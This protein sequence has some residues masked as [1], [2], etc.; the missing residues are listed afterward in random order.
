MNAP[1]RPA[2]ALGA[3]RIIIISANSPC[4]ARA[5]ARRHLVA[6]RHRRRRRPSPSRRPRR[7]SCRGP[8]PTPGP[9]PFL[10][11]LR[12]L[13]GGTNMALRRRDDT[14]YRTIEYMTVSPSP[15]ELGRLA[16]RVLADKTRGFRA[17]REQDNY[18]LGKLLRGAGDGPGRRELLSDS[19]ST[20][21]TSHT[22]SSA[23]TRPP[24]TRSRLA[25]APKHHQDDHGRCA[26]TPRRRGR[27]FAPR[28]SLGL[29]PVRHEPSDAWSAGAGGWVRLRVSGSERAWLVAHSML[30]LDNLDSR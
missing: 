15:G 22:P 6:S 23:A 17:V 16:A 27:R 1:L 25:G 12:A 4:T 18:L 24:S 26:T 14:P 28:S 3:T 7:P 29:P 30:L 11:Q 9:K 21:T 5:R 2:V 19:S 20:R 8:P 10:A 13:P